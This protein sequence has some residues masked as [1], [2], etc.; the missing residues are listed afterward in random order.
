MTERDK[1]ALDMKRY[2]IAYTVDGQ[3]VCPTSV[4]RY[5]PLDQVEVKGFTI[6]NTRNGDCPC[7][8]GYDRR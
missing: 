5:T 2:G 6:D 1:I 4:V 7:P 3:R 8:E